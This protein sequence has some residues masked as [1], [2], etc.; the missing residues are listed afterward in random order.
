M[1]AN[2]LA[3]RTLQTGAAYVEGHEDAGPP[4]AR[5]KGNQAT[6]GGV[7]RIAALCA[8]PVRQDSRRA[9][10]DGRDRT[11]GK[12]WPLPPEEGDRNTVALHVAY[13]EKALRA[14]LKAVGARWDPVEKVWR[15]PFSCVRGTELEERVLKD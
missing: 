10:E 14:K 9:P 12:A 5:T 3:R 11:G 1:R 8:L 13:T 7:R 2:L 15:V 4:E 6:R